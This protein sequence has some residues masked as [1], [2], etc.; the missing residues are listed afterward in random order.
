MITYPGLCAVSVHKRFVLASVCECAALDSTRSVSSS[1]GWRFRYG[2]PRAR[3]VLYV[4]VSTYSLGVQLR[5]GSHFCSF[6]YAYICIF[7]I[8][9]L[10]DQFPLNTYACAFVFL[11]TVKG[12]GSGRR[13][14][15]GPKRRRISILHYSYSTSQPPI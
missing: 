5:F 14:A 4:S 3:L 6:F 12:R 15:F 9:V 11:V 13:V 1:A 7:S 10:V 8:R 2:S